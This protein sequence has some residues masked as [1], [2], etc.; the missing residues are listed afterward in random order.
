MSSIVILA[1]VAALGI[2]VGWEPLAEG[3]HEY[4]IQIEPQLIDTL[5]EG[6]DIVSE[7][8]AQL[9]VRRY[10]V[11][12]GSGKLKRNDGE[13]QAALPAPPTDT[14]RHETPRHDTTARHDPP[15]RRDPPGS[16][17]LE[18]APR[19]A[20][21]PEEK[22]L[23]TDPEPDLPTIADAPDSEEGPIAPEPTAATETPP[24]KLHPTHDKSEFPD[25][26]AIYKSDNARAAQK[27]AISAPPDEPKPW[28]PFLTAAFLLC[29]SLGANVYLG[30]VA[31]DARRGQRIA[32]DKLRAVPS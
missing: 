6:T 22:P 7:V 23:E 8:P 4:T 28:W 32:L 3:G 14:P 12:I 25:Q 5:V 21:E 19:W 26:P 15:P 27:P 31:A 16:S 9:H 30:W 1:A 13:I 18:D 24:R 20:P 11:T 2:E 17:T 29:C 10:R